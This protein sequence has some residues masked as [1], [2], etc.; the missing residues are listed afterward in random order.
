MCPDPGMVKNA[1]RQLNGN[2]PLETVV[3]TCNRGFQRSSGDFIRVCQANGVW[4][5]DG[6]V[7]RTY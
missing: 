6:P 3:Y 1:Q 2:N 4:S 5:G 7:C